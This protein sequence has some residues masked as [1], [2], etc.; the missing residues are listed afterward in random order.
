MEEF[1]ILYEYI[2]RHN[3]GVT[4]GDFSNLIQLFDQNAQFRFLKIP[5]G[6]MIGVQDIAEGFS[7]HPPV[8][9][10]VIT[11][12]LMKSKTIVKA[13]YAWQNSSETGTIELHFLDNLIVTVLI[14]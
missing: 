8:D 10:L 14:D 6:P 3:E 13:V 7:K 11:N 12:L 4:T 9:H 1:D 2:K 5:F